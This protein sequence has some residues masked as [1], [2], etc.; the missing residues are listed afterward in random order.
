MKT[1]RFCIVALPL[2]QQYTILCNRYNVFRW[3]RYMIND[4]LDSIAKAGKTGFSSSDALRALQISKKA[5]SQAIYRLQKQGKLISP[6][7]GFYVPIPPEY[8]SLGCIP[9]DQLIPP[10][11]K[12][13]ETDYYICLL[14]AAMFHGAAHQ[15]P[16]ITQVMVAKRILPIRCGGVVINF[17]FKKSLVDVPTQ[18][19][20]V[21]T[22]YLKVSTP[23]ATAMDLLLY[24]FQ[25]GGISHIATVLT[26]LIEV[27]DPEKLLALAKNSSEI[28]WVQRLGVILERI[29]PDEPEN[30]DK[31]IQLLKNYIQEENPVYLPLARGATKGKPYNTEWKVIINTEV[32]SDI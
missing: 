21:R 10:L 16:Q 24:R 12:H 19:F 30:K 9:A 31:C 3:F 18:P 14:S 4:Y 32:E 22:G 25:A 15:R 26:E 27:I 2:F 23:E 13:I 28:A 6:Y 8:R 29:V 7:R 5:L 20:T 1:N 11:M 17:I